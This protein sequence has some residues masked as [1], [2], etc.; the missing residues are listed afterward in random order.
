MN[1][2]Y[3][4]SFCP[5]THGHNDVVNRALRYNYGA[6]TEL[7]KLYI[8]V[9]DNAEKD[10]PF[11][12]E[13]RRHMIE[14]ALKDHPHRD[15][16]KV[17]A[18]SG[19]TADI[20]Q[21]LNVSFLIRGIRAEQVEDEKEHLLAHSNKRLAKIRGFNLETAFIYSHD[22]FLG[23]I[24]STRV[25]TLYSMGEYIEASKLVPHNIHQHMVAYYLAAN[26]CAKCK[27][28][29][30]HFTAWESIVDIYTKRC[31]HNM[32]HIGHMFN[33]LNIYK[34]QTG[35]TP[36]ISLLLAIIGHD[37]VIDYNS[38]NNEEASYDKLVSIL[39]NNLQDITNLDVKKLIMA[40]KHT[41]LPDQASIEE[42]LIADL[43]LSILGTF[44]DHSWN[45]VYCD[46]IRAEASDISD[47]EFNKK[48][49]A[50][51]KRML[52][53]KRIFITDVF[54]NLYEERAR[55]NITRELEK[56]EAKQNA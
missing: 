35:Y 13:E 25:R 9:G 34:Y 23:S 50:F 33:M 11:S 31:Y 30:N 12:P 44:S 40:T 2:L 5:Y 4:G 37:L 14:E 24:S 17:I 26:S 53:R 22:E 15:K 46:G 36:S 10:S 1:V 52:E 21:R 6:G 32:T 39:R 41:E 49:I 7:E 43:D 19:I 55:L 51:L 56:L 8:C 29:I 3:M 38:E 28:P 16:I 54:Y 47:E 42:K 27:W 20:A 18:D 45:K 48:R